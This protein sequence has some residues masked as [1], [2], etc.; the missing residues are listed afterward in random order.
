[1]N[2]RLDRCW[3]KREPLGDEEQSRGEEKCLTLPLRTL[4]INLTPARQSP[5]NMRIGNQA[6]QGRRASLGGRVM[7]GRMLRWP[8]WLA[9]VVAV[10][11]AAVGLA[12]QPNKKT[13]PAP[14]LKPGEPAAHGI[15]GADFE[16]L[17]TILRKAVDDKA[18]PGVALLLAH[19]SEVIFKEAF[20]DLKEDKPVPLSS[21]S[22]PVSATVVMTI[23]D[24]GKMRLEDPLT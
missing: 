19:K 7:T 4:M 3:T 5:K 2:K 20:G 14:V 15:R 23:V 1:M 17:Q 6:I 10:L 18:V 12:D 9:V 24:Q 13:K 11:V 8:S 21:D 22:K 16:A